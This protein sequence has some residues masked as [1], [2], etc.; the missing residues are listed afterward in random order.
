MSSS[1]RD[2][3]EDTSGFIKNLQIAHSVSAF[4]QMDNLAHSVDRQ[5]A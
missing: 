5:V 4:S 3:D 1:V 2:A